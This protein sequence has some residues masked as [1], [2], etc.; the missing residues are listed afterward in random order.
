MRFVVGGGAYAGVRTGVHRAVASAT[1]MG[2]SYMGQSVEEKSFPLRRVTWQVSFCS[3]EKSQTFLKH[4]WSGFGAQK[5]GRFFRENKC[6][7]IV[8]RS[9]AARK[10]CPDSGPPP[11]T[12]FQAGFMVQFLT[13]QGLFLNSAESRKLC[14]RGESSLGRPVS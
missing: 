11:G 1:N 9:S 8:C 3:R 2:N 14:A 7:A 4:R 13:C 5:L 12:T 6:D 10:L